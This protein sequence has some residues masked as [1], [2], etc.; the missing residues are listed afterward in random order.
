[1]VLRLFLDCQLFNIKYS[2]TNSFM[3]TIEKNR[4]NVDKT[5]LNDYQTAFK[6]NH[7]FVLPK[8]FGDS[9]KTWI[10][11]F[12]EKASWHTKTYTRPNTSQSFGHEYQLDLDNKL[13][14]ILKFYL[15]HPKIIETVRQITQLE[16]IKSFEGRIFKF[17]GDNKCFG[18]WHTDIGPTMPDRLVGISLNLSPMPYNGGLFKLRTIKTQQLHKIVKHETW[19]G[20]HFFRI[21]PT[22]EHCITAVEGIHP[23][24]AYAGWF[25]STDLKQKI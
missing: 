15:N 12:L 14:K 7:V 4:V 8:F 21:D 10:Q 23:R 24:I 22:L 17:E 13:Y 1:M 19:G 18:N 20:V 25:L 6:N 16:T 11:S 3:I 2:I 9:L 5:Q